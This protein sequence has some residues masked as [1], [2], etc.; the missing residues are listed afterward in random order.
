ML[1][2]GDRNVSQAANGVTSMAGRGRDGGNTGRM[3][4]DEEFLDEIEER[5]V[6]EQVGQNTFCLFYVIVSLR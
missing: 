5:W 6:E 2:V 1:Q 3:K 4:E